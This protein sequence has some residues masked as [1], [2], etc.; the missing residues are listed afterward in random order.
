MLAETKLNHTGKKLLEEL[1]RDESITKE[2]QTKINSLFV[3]TNDLSNEEMQ[4]FK[5]VIDADIASKQV[6][7]EV[8]CLREK[9]SRIEI[10]LDQKLEAAV[11]NRSR[12]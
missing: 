9:E 1:L 7:A 4:H 8:R 5:M 10:A 11:L 2:Q 6:P 12:S 3:K